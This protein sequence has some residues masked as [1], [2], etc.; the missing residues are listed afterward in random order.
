V[1]VLKERGAEVGTLRHVLHLILERGRRCDATV[2][3]PRTQLT[4]PRRVHLTSGPALGLVCRDKWPVPSQ[5][6]M[7]ASWDV[8]TDTV[9]QNAA[10]YLST[11][12]SQINEWI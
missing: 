12:H 7:I 4:G 3:D 10:L 2:R 5:D 1:R 6:H 11:S 8:T 9:A